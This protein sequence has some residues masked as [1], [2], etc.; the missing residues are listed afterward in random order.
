MQT[1]QYIKEVK[2]TILAIHGMQTAHLLVSPVV[3]LDNDCCIP[4]R[5]ILTLCCYASFVLPVGV[6]NDFGCLE[7]FP[8]LAI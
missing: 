6:L 5:F 4:L 1:Q 7:E 2:T 3:T 8:L